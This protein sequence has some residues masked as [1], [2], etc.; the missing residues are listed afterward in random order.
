MTILFK[1][2]C[3]TYSNNTSNSSSIVAQL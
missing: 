2:R 1:N 3:S